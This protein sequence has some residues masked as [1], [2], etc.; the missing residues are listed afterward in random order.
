MTSLSQNFPE[1]I[2]GL[3]DYWR[4][5]L[6]QR[7]GC[8]NMFTQYFSAKVQEALGPWSSCCINAA[9]LVL[10]IDGYLG[11]KKI[12]DLG[13]VCLKRNKRCLIL[14]ASGTPFLEVGSQSRRE[15]D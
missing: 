14:F 5:V 1:E 12:F 15:T 7:F 2:S 3:V 11:N 4:G 10:E 8:S 6:D 13:L 9:R